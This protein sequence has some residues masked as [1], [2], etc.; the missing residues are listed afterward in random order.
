MAAEHP[1]VGRLR[2]DQIATA[3]AGLAR[4]ETAPMPSWR[5]DSWRHLR[6]TYYYGVPELGD[7]ARRTWTALAPAY[8]AATARIDSLDRLMDW[9]CQ[10][11]LVGDVTGKR[12]L[13]LGCGTGSKAVYWALNGATEVFG[14]DISEPFI[15]ALRTSETPENVSWICADV[16]DLA[17]V[18]ELRDQTFD[19]VTILCASLGQEPAATFSMIRDMLTDDGVLVWTLAH[20]VRWAVER[21]ERDGVPVGRGYQ[22]RSW[23]SYPSAWD[24]SVQ[25]THPTSRF[26]DA[27]NG[28]ADAGFVI[29]TC[30]EPQLP[31]DVA[32]RFPHKQEWL[33]KYV[34]LLAFRARKSAR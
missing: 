19:I 5:G 30:V 25:V 18:S 12:L 27:V 14:L 21:A 29:E 34:G 2:G 33:D 22:D 4:A 15:Q 26:S 32:E 13:D 11:G 3:T 6:G 7:L 16:A 9:P 20:P 28:L 31:T 24:P 10:Q 23:M 1:L 17:A 8:D